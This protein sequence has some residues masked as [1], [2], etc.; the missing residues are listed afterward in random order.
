[1]TDKREIDIELIKSVATQLL[2]GKA[3]EIGGQVLPIRKIGSR[4]LRMVKFEM[5]GREYEAIEQNAS[6][7]STWGKLARQGHLV[8]QFRDID[9]S[10]YVAVAIDG[11]VR[12]YGKMKK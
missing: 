2:T 10:K 9:R 7:P 5:N 12:E 1:M 8:V 4:R 11:E 6:K 3:V